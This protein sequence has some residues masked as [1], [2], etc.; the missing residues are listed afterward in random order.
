MSNLLNLILVQ[1]DNK[2]FQLSRPEKL[3][4]LPFKATAVCNWPNFEYIFIRG[5]TY[6]TCE[7]ADERKK[8]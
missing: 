8:Q 1:T 5:C 6:Y 7:F 2:W 3:T 4:T